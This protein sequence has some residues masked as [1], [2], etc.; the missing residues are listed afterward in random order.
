[1]L[2]VTAREIETDAVESIP[3][4]LVTRTSRSG[5]RTLAVARVL[6]T[7]IFVSLLVLI[8]LTAIP[9]GTTHAWWEALFVCAIFA[10]AIL[11]LLEGLLS[12]A[13]FA[14]SGPLV[15]PAIGLALFSFLQTLALG[16]QNTIRLAS[17]RS[18]Y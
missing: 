7:T 3:R 15:L 14:D 10:L 2:P 16:G 18:C 12:N 17:L 1:M 5:V 13:W 6:S 11:W 4:G 8:V 9:Y